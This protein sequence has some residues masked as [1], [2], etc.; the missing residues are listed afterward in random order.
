R[1]AIVFAMGL[2]DLAK[3][4][5]SDSIELDQQ[6]LVDRFHEFDVTHI[7]ELECRKSARIG[8]EVRRIRVAP[9]HGVAS[10]E[11]V[12]SDGTGDAVAVF[13]GRRA[14]AG[15]EH[16]RALVIEGVAHDERGHRV[17]LNPAYTLL[18]S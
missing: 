11:V 9:R 16:G 10:L 4:L 15:I 5:K 2:R 13:T 1:V 8:G 18:S 14:I 7:S 17:M 3:R 6:R 12:L